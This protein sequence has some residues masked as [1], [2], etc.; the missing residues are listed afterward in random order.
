EF[1]CATIR[2]K[3]Q[4]QIQL[5][6]SCHP[7]GIHPVAVLSRRRGQ[8]PQGDGI[9]ETLHCK[10]TL[11]VRREGKQLRRYVHVS[12]GNYNVLTAKIYTDIGLFTCDPEFGNDVSSLFNVLTGFNS[13]TGGICSH[14]RRWRRCSEGS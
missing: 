11:V 1:L 4:V 7:A 2:P 6:R 9:Q 14:P 12:S 13:W 10:A 3:Y 5:L 8:V